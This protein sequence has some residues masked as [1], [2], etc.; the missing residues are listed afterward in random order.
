[1]TGGTYRKDVPAEA[2]PGVWLVERALF[3]CLGISRA[4]GSSGRKQQWTVVLHTA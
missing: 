2:P 4:V 3:H 1:M